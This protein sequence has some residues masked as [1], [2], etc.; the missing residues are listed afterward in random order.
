MSDPIRSL[1]GWLEPRGLARNAGSDTELIEYRDRVDFAVSLIRNHEIA[2]WFER[3]W[4]VAE[5]I[6]AR[7]PE[8]T[9]MSIP[10]GAIWIDELD[11]PPPWR[12][13]R[14]SNGIL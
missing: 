3:D 10:T 13:P 11:R 1:L 4:L 12:R 14:Q 8:C 7:C 5:L 6:A 2:L 9:V